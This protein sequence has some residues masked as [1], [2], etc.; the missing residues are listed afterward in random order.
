[1][2]PGIQTVGSDAIPALARQG[3]RAMPEREEY[4]GGRSVGDG[5][6]GSVT[7][8]AGASDLENLEY[9]V[10]AARSSQ[11]EREIA[12]AQ[13][14]QDQAEAHI[15]AARG[16]WDVHKMAQAVTT[17]PDPNATVEMGH[18]EVRIGNLVIPRNAGAPSPG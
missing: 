18:Q 16:Q 12:A 5:F 1:M 9:E 4:S 7:P 6:L 11:S 17:A 13:A 8:Q 3:V 15:K 14:T 2:S 10:L